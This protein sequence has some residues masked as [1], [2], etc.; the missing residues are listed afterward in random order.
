MAR[1]SSL[2][3]IPTMRGEKGRTDVVIDRFKI[4]SRKDLDDYF[5]ILIGHY[6]NRTC[7]SQS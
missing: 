4:G 5:V 1:D 6:C 3:K 7:C 2:A